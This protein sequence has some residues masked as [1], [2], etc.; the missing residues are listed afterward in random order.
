MSG[1]SE[2]RN[3]Y[4][5]ASRQQRA[6]RIFWS[7]DLLGSLKMRIN[8]SDGC[9]LHVAQSSLANYFYLPP[10]KIENAF[11]SAIDAN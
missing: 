4:S 1:S 10:S 6:I 7:I 8:S 9:T 2:A 11:S 5:T 3:K